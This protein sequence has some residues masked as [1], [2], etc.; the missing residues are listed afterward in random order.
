MSSDES[1]KAAAA[2][3]NPIVKDDGA[4]QK[5]RMLAGRL[6]WSIKDPELVREHEHCGKLVQAF[7]KTTGVLCLSLSLAAAEG[8]LSIFMST[9]TLR[10]FQT[11]MG[12]GV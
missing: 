1:L 3:E 6:Y 2:K 7:N 9:P 12:T 10:L 11:S 4:T 5:Q 8:L